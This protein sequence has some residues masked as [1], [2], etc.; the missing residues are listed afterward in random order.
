MAHADPL[1]GYH[2]KLE[3]GGML[4]GSFRGLSVA[5][6]E[7][8]HKV[9]ENLSAIPTDRAA[10]R[11]TFRMMARPREAPAAH[12]PI[13][14][15]IPG[16]LKW[17]DV[18]L[19]SVARPRPTTQP[20]AVQFQWGTRHGIPTTR[21]PINQLRQKGGGASARGI[22]TNMDPWVWRKTIETG[23]ALDRSAL[24]WQPTGLEIHGFVATGAPVARSGEMQSGRITLVNDTG[25]P[26]SRWEFEN[27]WP[28]KISGPAAGS[29]EGTSLTLQLAGLRKT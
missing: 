25:T 15:K 17:T 3:I 6:A 24:K 18:T 7:G 28:S 8:G 2:F 21:A 23:A 20:P 22:T 13:V 19:K 10:A 14:R 11:P 12:P 5:P 29:D 26:I 1:T 27:A 9:S 4:I 16:R